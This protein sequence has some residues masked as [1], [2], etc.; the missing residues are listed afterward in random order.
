MFEQMTEQA[1][2]KLQVSASV[3]FK[4]IVAHPHADSLMMQQTSFNIAMN[5]NLRQSATKVHHKQCNTPLTKL[6]C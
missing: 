1:H 4:Y 2:V 6:G 5:T 3:S